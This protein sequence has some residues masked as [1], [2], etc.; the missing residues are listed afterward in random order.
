M[1]EQER[2]RLERHWQQN[3][4]RARY[5]VERAA[6]Q[7]QAVEP[8]NRLVA[9]ELE[10]RWEQALQAQRVLEL[11]AG[12]GLGQL[13]RLPH[14]LAGR[15][16]PRRSTGAADQIECPQARFPKAVGD[17]G[18][19]QRRQ[20]AERPD[21]QPLQHGG[22][23]RV[24]P[25]R[26]QQADRERPQVGARGGRVAGH[27]LGAA[28]A[29]AG[30]R[31]QRAEARG[32]GPHP[33]LRPPDRTPGVR[34]HPLDAP[35]QPP[36]AARLEAHQPRLLGRNGRADPLQPRQHQLPGLGHPGGIGRHE[37]ESRAARQRL[38]QPHP[39]AH[40][41]RL[42]GRRGLPDRLVPVTG[43]GRQRGGLP[44]Q[45]PPVADGDGELE[46]RQ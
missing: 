32:T 27:H 10:R 9:I 41:E 39:G 5:E 2:A 33:R 14:A 29:G 42:G 24:D 11:R 38:P 4:Q 43:R 7:Y 45:H 19:R 28:R 36:Q 34:D 22:Q 17:R 6:R 40:A 8:E 21:A 16:R 3:R 30:R 44:Q 18:A 31:R 13:E 37:R 25:R 12:G 1:V 15:A 46:A 23:L 20:R 35:E 26:A